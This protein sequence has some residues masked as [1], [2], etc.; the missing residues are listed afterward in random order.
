MA[1]RISKI[2]NLFDSIQRHIDELLNENSG[3]MGKLREDLLRLEMNLEKALPRER[4]AVYREIISGVK[5]CLQGME[6]RETTPEEIQEIRQLVTEIMDNL[7]TDVLGEPEF[8]KLV[9]VKKKVVVFIP[10]KASMWDCMESIWQAA[11]ADPDCEA[12]V[13]PIP[14][15]ERNSEDYSLGKRHYEGDMLPPYVPIVDNETYDIAKERPD[16]VYTHYCYDDGNLVTSVDPRYYSF[17]LC[18]Y[19]PVLM[20]V[21]YFAT[22]GGMQENQGYCQAYENFDCIVIQSEFLRRFY[23]PEIPAEKIQAL[24]SPKFDKVIKCCQ[25]PPPVPEAWTRKMQGKKVY[26]F[27][28][29][30]GGLIE[31]AHS[32]LRKMRYVFDTFKHHKEACLLWR[33]H[34]LMEETLRSMLPEQ[35][36]EYLELREEFLQGDWGI[37][38]DTPDLEKT[39]ALCDVYVGDVG[40]SLIALFGVAGKP[41]FYLKNWLHELPQPHDWRGEILNINL[42]SPDWLVA[43]NGNFYHAAEHDF[44]YKFFDHYGKWHSAFY[45]N[46]VWE[47]DGRAFACPFNAREILELQQDGSVRHISLK[48]FEG[49]SGIFAGAWTGKERYLFLLPFRY[50]A[51]VRYDIENDEI[52]YK[53]RLGTGEQDIEVRSFLTACQNGIWHIGGHTVWRNFLILGTPLGQLV[54]LLDMD[55]LETRVFQLPLEGGCGIIVP[56]DDELWILPMYGGHV[57]CWQPDNGNICEYDGLPEGFQAVEPS[58]GVETGQLPFSSAAFPDEQHVLL[59][60][61]RGNMFV[62]LDRISGQM[63]EWESPF[64]C[65]LSNLGGYNYAWIVG[66]F[67]YHSGYG[68]CRYF[69]M[70]ERRLFDMDFQRME[71]DEIPLTVETDAL[72]KQPAGFAELSEWNRYGCEESAFNTLEGLLSHEIHGEQFNRER[73]LAAYGEIAANMDGTAGEKIHRHAL[74]LLRAKGGRK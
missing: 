36:Q 21:P 14:Y 69:Y 25:N 73:Q 44:H 27:N 59:A 10:Y 8:A 40:T 13:M 20:Y 43:E 6:Q 18:R 48:P 1:S 29:S 15:Y 64:D 39:I 12:I 61:C 55:T 37:Y 54:A 5:D 66:G 74:K 23:S 35:Y 7:Q 33:P 17:E 32:F 22:A 62:L 19:V 67:A 11:A 56:H 58:R 65:D 3:C 42:F 72:T 51:L 4:H 50:P 30:L 49:Q 28:T 41:C 26:F 34:P 71:A 52:I 38:D 45:W 70:R 53:E 46:Q 9:T 57:V 31:N 2:N 24:G 16:I 47:L 60:P 63:T 68:K